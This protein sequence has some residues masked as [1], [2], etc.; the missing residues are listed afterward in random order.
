[1]RKDA[2]DYAGPKK[3]IA[4]RE[5]L[6]LGDAWRVQEKHDGEYVR[7]HLDAGGR[8][9]RLFTR[10]GNEVSDTIAGDVL[11]ALVGAPH[12]ELVGELEAH[13]EAGRR[14]AARRGHA[15]VHLFDVIRDGR[16]Y[17]AREPYAARY[18]ALHAMNV[19]AASAAEDARYVAGHR[20]RDLESG[21]Y[22]ADALGP[23]GLL[24]APIV[25]MLSRRQA[26]EVWERARH[27]EAEGLV[28]V[29][30][31]APLGA[32]GGKRKCKH[33]DTLDC[34]VVEIGRNAALLEAGT[35]RFP[36]SAKGIALE[37]GAWVE[38]KFNGWNR[39]SNTP[40]HARIL[41]L[42]RDLGATL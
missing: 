10:A 17:L 13:T 20:T 2:P 19:W 22:S 28:A 34:R 11:G 16:R 32:G 9:A 5:L 30:M 7:I 3:T 41:R 29:A 37:P 6:E 38:V 33:S 24:R 42:R 8:I 18:R 40:R 26:E 15:A 23:A 35:L 39:R 4:F 31:N 27:D 36:V 12:A 14:A 1:M 21:R 25:E